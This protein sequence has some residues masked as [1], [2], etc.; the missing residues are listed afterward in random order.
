MPE[1]VETDPDGV[2][3]GWVMQVTF[4]TTIVVGVPVVTFLSSGADL[5]TWGARAEFAIRAGVPIWFVTSIL[6]YLYERY[7]R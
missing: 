4:V 2:D 1:R 7:R 6:A 5:P 3:F